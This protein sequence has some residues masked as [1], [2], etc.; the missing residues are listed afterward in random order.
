MNT[1]LFNTIVETFGTEPLAS[2]G[3]TFAK[4]LLHPDDSIA[5]YFLNADGLRDTLALRGYTWEPRLA[6]WIKKVNSVEEAQQE[7]AG[8]PATAAAM[9]QIS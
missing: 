1:E 4:V 5:I 6:A 2:S 3:K 7:T 8:Y 9:S